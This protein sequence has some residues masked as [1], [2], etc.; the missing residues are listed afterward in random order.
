M[1]NKKNSNKKNNKIKIMEKIRKKSVNYLFTLLLILFVFVGC[2]IKQNMVQISS[3]HKQL[4]IIAVNDIHAAIDNFPRFAFIVDSLRNIY[5]DLLL[6]SAGDNVSGNPV[7]DQYTEVGM[8]IFYLMN[9]MKFDL[10]AIGNHELNLKQNE[11]LNI[12]K[13]TDFDFVNANI[14]PP[15]GKGYNIK[16]YKII[17]LSNGL[18]IN[19]VSILNINS[20]GITDSHPDNVKGFNFDNPKEIALKYLFLKDSCDIFIY[21]NHYGYEN[22]IELAK[23]FHPNV[24]DLIIG[25][26]T[27]TKIE[28]EE[29]YN[30]IMITQAECKLEYATFIKMDVA[31]D[32]KITRSMQLLKVGNKGSENA[33]IRKIVN[34]FNDKSDLNNQ[35]AIAETDFTSTEQI[36]YLMTDALRA[37]TSAD[38]AVINK[39]AVRISTLVK[40]KITTKDVYTMDPFRNEMMV[41]KITGK[42]L[43]NLYKIAYTADKYKFIFASGVYSKYYFDKEGKLK[44]IKLFTTDWKDFDLEKTYIVAMNSYMPAVYMFGHSE[45]G[46]NYFTTTSENMLNYLKELEYV[47]S[48]QNESRLEIIKE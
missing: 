27:H 10:T 8:P 37:G 33:E 17:K 22:D 26:H 23:S 28:E 11:L 14:R 31:P 12:I 29:F 1:K 36:A 19:F 44:D 32:G 18:K 43:L 6:V 5:P 42:E 13:K 21:L 3:Q 2:K 25:G 24:V 16:P 39:G 20:F 34:E 15:K 35:I 45:A 40:G 48:Y 4:E 38:I 47:P 9:K 7:N 30:N 41:F 46:I